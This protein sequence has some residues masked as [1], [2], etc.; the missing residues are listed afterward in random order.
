MPFHGG[1]LGQ[2]PGSPV[3]IV[4][5]KQRERRPEIGHHLRNVSS[6]L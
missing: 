6:T 2:L 1:N 5:E 4:F 3:R